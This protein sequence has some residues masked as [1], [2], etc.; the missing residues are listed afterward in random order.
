MR[1]A[2][3]IAILFAGTVLAHEPPPPLKN[4]PS[5]TSQAHADSSARSHSSSHSASS[6]H[7][8]QTQSQTQ[9]STQT[10]NAAGGEGGSV[11]QNYATNTPDVLPPSNYPTVPCFRPAS[12][13]LSVKGFGIGGGA[14]ALDE[15]CL[16]REA[17]RSKRET[18]QMFAALGDR[19]AAHAVLCATNDA[20]EVFGD[21]C[22]AAVDP[23]APTC[24]PSDAATKQDVNEAVDK[25]F[26]ACIQK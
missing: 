4:T 8:E 23:P 21:K 3:L 16:K 14:G 10:T 25:A 12:G 11:T 22:P 1:I 18:A 19:V 13:G 26:K 7:Q 17:D 5:S 9:S 6:A 15:A 20:R 24:T 2:A